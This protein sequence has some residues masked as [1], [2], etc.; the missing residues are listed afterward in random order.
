M[1]GNALVPECIGHC[2]LVPGPLRELAGSFEGGSCRAV[3]APDNLM[4]AADPEQ[5]PSLAAQVAEHPVELCCALEQRQLLRVLRHLPG[6][7]VSLLQEPPVD[8]P[9]AGQGQVSFHRVQF[10]VC[11]RQRAGVAIEYGTLIEQPG[12]LDP[13]FRAHRRLA[14][15]YRCDRGPAVTPSMP[16]TVATSATSCTAS[17]ASPSAMKRGACSLPVSIQNGPICVPGT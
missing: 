10:P 7:C 8:D 3:I 12:S 14:C 4:E 11:C 2:H 9:A 17:P 15:A 6:I 13:V 1:L 5:G 16:I